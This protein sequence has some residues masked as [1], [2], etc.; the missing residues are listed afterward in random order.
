MPLVDPVV[1][2]NA[3]TNVEA[4]LIKL[5]LTEAGIEV[6]AAEDLSLGGLWVFGSLP[7]IH[8]PQVFVGRSDVERARPVVEAYEAEVAER[9]ETAGPASRHEMAPIEVECDQCHTKTLFPASRRGAIE[10]CP[11]C[12]EYL[13]VGEVDESDPYWLVSEEEE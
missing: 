3:A 7:G 9:H 11:K 2:Y 1:I 8:K 10:N 5:R 4:Q 6:F 12:G 13:D